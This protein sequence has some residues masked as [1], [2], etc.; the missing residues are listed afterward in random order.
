MSAMLTILGDASGVARAIGDA[1][2]QAR[3]ATSALSAD[4][5]RESERRRRIESEEVE[6]ARAAWRSLLRDRQR[7]A[8]DRQRAEEAASKRRQQLERDEKTAA[9]KTARDKA[10]ATEKAERERTKSTER[11]TRLRQ[12]LEDGAKRRAEADARE[13][14]RTHDREERERTKTTEREEKRR[15]R[16]AEREASAAMRRDAAARRGY[17]D[18]GGVVTR[19]GGALFSAGAA[20]ARDLHGQFQD[21]RRQRARTRLT[22]GS[23]LVEAGATRDEA[24]TLFG[25]LSTQALAHGMDADD[26]AGAVAAAQTEFSVLGNAQELRGMNPQA[27]MQ[28]LRGRLN[29]AI[30]RAVQGRNLGADPGEFLRLSGM[31]TNQ[32]FDAGTIDDLLARTVAMAQRGAIEPGAVTRQAMT[33]IMQRMQGAMS[34]L[35]PGASAEAR[36]AAARSAYLQSFSELQVLRSRGWNP[37]NGAN[38]MAALDQSLT[39]NVT[40]ARMQNN[41][42][43][44][45]QGASGPLRDSLRTLLGTGEGGLFE[46]DPSRRGQVRLREAFRGNAVRLSATLAQAG[47]TGEQTANLFAGGGHGNAQSM[48]ANW[49]RLMQSMLGTN[50]EGVTGFAAVNELGQANLTRADRS[51]MADFY[52]NSDAAN[53]NRNEEARLQALGDNTGALRNLSDRFADWTS[54]NPLASTLGGTAAAMG[55]GIVGQVGGRALGGLFGLAGG[56]GAVP[57]TAALGAP[58][59]AAGTALGAGGAGTG[60]A[61]LGGA[62]LGGLAVAGAAA[63]AG[64]AAGALDSGANYQARVA[65]Q[66]AARR[67]RTESVLGISVAQRDAP[68]VDLSSASVDALTR[69]LERAR[70][71]ATVDPHDAQHA[72]SQSASRAG[73]RR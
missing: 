7:A 3:R 69:A 55:G 30:G 33:P 24:N 36:S 41:L 43:V 56:A 2:G 70:L 25:S 53:L 47:L 40:A 71:T 14:T 15:S 45:S 39:S 61:A 18:A 64:L 49:R 8:R 26:L 12:K 68:A 10:K 21:A 19:V 9:E 73:G 28:A 44:A 11:E 13:R 59:T 22:L 1:V 38:A 31:F 32:G 54:R 57:V 67:E 17:R 34:A 62:A 42:Q 6:S 48:Q 72:A 63:F 66:N 65:A 58:G 20:G 52:E 35:G 23:K 27:R 46:A 50:A 60:G 5:R 51:R 16:L 37:R 4:A 29:A